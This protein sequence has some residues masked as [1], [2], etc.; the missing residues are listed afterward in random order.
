MTLQRRQI[1]WG[2][3][4]SLT[5]GG[6]AVGAQ[7]LGGHAAAPELKGSQDLGAEDTE[8]DALP[9]TWAQ[10]D[11]RR[12]YVHNLHTDEKLNAVYY[13]N[14]RY[15]PGVLA[16]AKH[17]L[18]DWRNNQQHFIDP[19]LFDLLH[20]LR[21]KIA[22]NQPFQ[23]LSGYRSPATNAMLHAHSEQVAS[24]SQHL[25]GKALDINVEGVDLTRL[26]RA[27]LSLRAGGVGYYPD[28]GFVHVDVGRLRAWTDV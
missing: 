24:R 23:I 7:M 16:E 9:S 28:N 20:N 8:V 17:I 2:G 22:S 19:H 27:A 10:E 14:G 4:A 18:R 12:A 25:L 1:L 6:A 11:V 13:E 5:A 21:T 3:L 15:V 26:H